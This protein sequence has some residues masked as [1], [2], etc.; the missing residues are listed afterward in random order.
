MN[1]DIQKEEMRSAVLFGKAVLFTPHHIALE[2]MPLGWNR[3]DLRGTRQRP[4]TASYLEDK[5]VSYRIGSV[6]SPVPLKKLSTESRRIGGTFLLLGETRTLREFCRGEGLHYPFP[7]LSLALR[8][9][10]PDEAGL[11]Y[12]LSPEKDAELGAVGHIRIDFGSEGN[13]FWHT[14]WSRGPEELNTPDFKEEL[15]RVVDGLRESVLKNLSSMR[16]YCRK[17]QDGAIPGGT[18]CQNYGFVLETDHYIYRLRCNPIKGDYQAHL[19][20][21]DKQAQKHG[22]GLTEK[23]RQALRDAADPAKLHN[24]CWYVIENNNGG[25]IRTAHELP[26]EEAV[27]LYAVLDCADK[28][29]GVIKDDISTVDLAISMDDQE[30]LPKDWQEMDDFKDDPVVAKAVE[31][32]RQAL[33]EQTQEQGL[34]MGGLG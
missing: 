2:D 15:S 7:A 6:L 29:L 27:Q 26:L 31:Q 4:D 10:S 22:M 19:T 23:G 32:I 17:H 24:Y 3:Y 30:W 11:F 34:T 25:G 12:R 21:F 14:W 28:C 33:E 13:E 5:S 18:R 8:P 16:K 20:C 1:I 9:A